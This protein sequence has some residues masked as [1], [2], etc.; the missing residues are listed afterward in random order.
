[1]LHC[2]FTLCN[3]IFWC[4]IYLFYFCFLL[5]RDR[6]IDKEESCVNL[7]SLKLLFLFVSP[8][9]LNDMRYIEAGIRIGYTDLEGFFF[10]SSKEFYFFLLLF[11]GFYI[12][13]HVYTLLVSH[14]PPSLQGRTCSCSALFSDTEF[15]YFEI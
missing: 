4:H 15:K 1:L 2:L 7:S 12:Y 13:L 8:W 5:T 10:L 6:Q 11:D 14:P 3:L 9:N